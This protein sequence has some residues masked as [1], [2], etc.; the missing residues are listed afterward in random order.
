MELEIFEAL[1]SVNVP[2]EKARAVAAS[3]KREINE[4]YQLHAAQL[5]TKADGAEL[6]ARLRKDLADMQRWTVASIFAA[7]ALFAA[8]VKIWH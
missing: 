3:L 6:E 2:A 7:V 4:H 8:I 1:T 5:F